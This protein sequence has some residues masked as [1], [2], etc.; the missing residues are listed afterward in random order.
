MPCFELEDDHF[1]YKNVMLVKL[2]LFANNKVVVFI[3][4]FN[5]FLTDEN[6]KGGGED[7]ILLR[8][9]KLV[10]QSNQE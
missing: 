3:F 7:F 10:N 1:S 4:E 6:K 8:P 9:N 2:L 5:G